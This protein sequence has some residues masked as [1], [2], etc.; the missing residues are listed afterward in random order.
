MLLSTGRL[1]LQQL[2][3]VD[4]DTHR[5]HEILGAGGSH[6]LIGERSK[7]LPYNIFDPFR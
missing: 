5:R 2:D 4:S 3:L 6:H 7:Y 1:T